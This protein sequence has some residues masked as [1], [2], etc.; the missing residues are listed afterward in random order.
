MLLSPTAAAAAAAEGVNNELPIMHYEAG[1]F[2]GE[3]AM[4]VNEP[5]AATVTAE[6][7]LCVLRLDRSAYELVLQVR[8]TRPVVGCLDVVTVPARNWDGLGI[9]AWFALT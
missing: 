6:A 3:R 8:T 2:F 9:Q 4:L 7:D 1:D 5:R